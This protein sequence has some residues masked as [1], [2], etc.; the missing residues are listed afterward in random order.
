MDEST[1]R[2]VLV[3]DDDEGYQELLTSALSSLYDVALCAT[4]EDGFRKSSGNF[5]I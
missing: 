5:F 1:R 4:V 2:R 3:I